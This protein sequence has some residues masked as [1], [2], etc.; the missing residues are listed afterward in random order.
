MVPSFELKR[1]VCEDNFVLLFRFF[2]RMMDN[3]QSIHDGMNSVERIFKRVMD[4]LIACCCLVVFS[5]IFLFC[6]VAIKLDDGGPV[7]FRQERIGR[8]G[9]SFRIYKFRSM[10]VNAEPSGPQLCVTADD[11]R[12]TRIGVFLRAH[13]WDEFPQLWNVLKGEMSLIGPR[14]ERQYYINQIMKADPRYR[15]LFQ[16]RP[17]VTSYATLYNGYTD[18]L[19]KMLV[20]LQYDLYYLQHRSWRMDLHI[21]WLTFLRMISGRKF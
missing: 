7:I 8:W 15:Y 2:S 13:H 11:E 3:G 10:R 1:T 14:P 16:I 20:R 6:F 17:G 12:L 19:E 21:L 4:V 18:T 5:P 9:K